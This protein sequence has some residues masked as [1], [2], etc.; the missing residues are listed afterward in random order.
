MGMR[1]DIR[2]D[3]QLVSAEL[4]NARRKDPKSTHIRFEIMSND[5]SVCEQM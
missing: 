3:G 1:S 2:E 5:D 4:T